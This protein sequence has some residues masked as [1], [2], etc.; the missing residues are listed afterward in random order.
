MEINLTNEKSDIQILSSCNLF[1]F[2]LRKRYKETEHRRVV[3]FSF[4]FKTFNLRKIFQ[5]DFFGVK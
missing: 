3:V 1:D 5:R 4:I 2:T